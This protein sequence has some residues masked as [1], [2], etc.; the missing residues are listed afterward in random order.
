MSSFQ[1]V[2]SESEAD[3]VRRVVEGFPV[4]SMVVMATF[5]IRGSRTLGS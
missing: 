3:T 1:A 4:A 2:G 5:F